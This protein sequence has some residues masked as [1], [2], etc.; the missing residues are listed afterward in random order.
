MKKI[1]R[2]RIGSIL[3]T[4]AMLLSLLPVTAGASNTDQC[5]DSNECTHEAAIGSIHY[6]TL[7]E[8]LNAATNGETVTLL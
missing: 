1:T 3:L 5:L 6:D 8:A 2:T 7:Q 4:M